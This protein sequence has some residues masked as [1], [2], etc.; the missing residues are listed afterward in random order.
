MSAIVVSD[1]LGYEGFDVFAWILLLGFIYV[2]RLLLCLSY[3]LTSQRFFYALSFYIY[4]KNNNN[5]MVGV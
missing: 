2:T 4:T 1:T 5:F 3:G